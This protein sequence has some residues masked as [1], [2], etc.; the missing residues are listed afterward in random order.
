MLR[1]W[2]A[3]NNVLFLAI[4][5][6]HH[7]QTQHALVWSFAWVNLLSNLWSASLGFCRGTHCHVQRECLQ[8]RS[9]SADCI[10]ICPLIC[11]KSSALLHSH[12]LWSML[13]RIPKRTGDQ[14][15]TPCLLQAMNHTFHTHSA[16]VC[17]VTEGT[18]KLHRASLKGYEKKYV[19]RDRFDLQVSEIGMRTPS[20]PMDSGSAAN[21]PERTSSLTKT[22]KNM[23]VIQFGRLVSMRRENVPS[24]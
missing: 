16:V 6:M 23:T 8:F 4:Q 5:H 7:F 2:D 13:N 17:L 21:W 22:G 3:E 9:P 15:Q 10:G 12:R 19:R 14:T 18:N 24:W 20:V 11:T 1:T